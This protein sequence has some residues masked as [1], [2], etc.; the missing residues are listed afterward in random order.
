MV[1][2]SLRAYH[3]EINQ[4]I[5]NGY[6]DR[7][8]THCKHILQRFPKHVDTYRLLGNAY[9]ELYKFTE[10]AE[11][12]QR[13]L[14]AVPDDRLAHIGMSVIREEEANLDEAIW[15]MERA[16]ELQSA[17]RILQDE[18]RRLYGLRDGLMPPRIYLTRPALARM[19]YKGKL[20]H[21]AIA[22][23][24]AVLKEEPIRIDLRLLLARIYFQ[25][26]NHSE[27]VRTA[28]L[29]LE[30]LPY[31]L[32]ANQ[33][34]VEGLKA[35]GEMENI[36]K[37][38]ERTIELDPYYGFI[39]PEI[40]SVDQ[41]PDQ[42]ISLEW[43]EDIANAEK[44]L[45][46]QIPDQPIQLES[47]IVSQEA[48]PEWVEELAQEIEVMPGGQSGSKIDSDFEKSPD[49]TQGGVQ[50]LEEKPISD[51][52][53]KPVRIQ[54]HPHSFEG[55]EEPDSGSSH[56]EELSEWISKRETDE[57]EENGN[58]NGEGKVMGE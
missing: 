6:A 13:L 21:Q 38:L 5:E 14:S 41:V 2:I 23:L 47:D 9:L 3:R 46:N 26:G 49:K 31:C 25:L 29:V 51:D 40:P 52:D 36:N 19:Y 35:E 48:L 10:A 44:R 11:I 55:A 57:P 18:L 37:H 53:T 50:S 43:L 30:K 24:H 56:G 17:N 54:G 12:L 27:A 7:A 45:Q 16:Y 58:L 4:M 20:Y 32:E 42:A 33:I 34:M 8:I 22:E 1:D 15:H 39:S 28:R